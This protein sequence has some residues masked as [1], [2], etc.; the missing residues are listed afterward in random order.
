MSVKT[1]KQKITFFSLLMLIS[2]QVFANRMLTFE[3]PV[4]VKDSDSV[5]KSIKIE[6]D[7]Q[8]RII[9]LKNLNTYEYSVKYGEISQIIVHK[10]NDTQNEYYDLNK[11][12]LN[13]SDNEI[14]F[15][16]KNANINYIE[17]WKFSKGLLTCTEQTTNLIEHYYLYKKIEDG[18]IAN[19][20]EFMQTETRNNKQ[21]NFYE[22]SIEDYNF[23]LELINQIKSKNQ[24]INILNSKVFLELEFEY[25][26]P[27][28]LIDLDKLFVTVESYNATSELKEKNAS[29]VAENLRKKEGLPWA[30]ANGYGIGEKINILLPTSYFNLYF[31]N[32]FQ[33]DSRKD[34]YKANSRV[35]KIRI[36][37]C[38]I[39]VSKEFIIKDVPEAQ[40]INLEDLCL[41]INVFTNL[42]ITILEIYPGEKYKDLCI[43]A[44]IPVY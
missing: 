8:G 26:I 12:N 44:I 19:Y 18:F 25:F 24:E 3:I 5:Y 36:R 42:E 13:V 39:D 35:K 9:Y 16:K 4:P 1:K 40:Y 23:P 17:E 20:I 38:E 32:G 10:T 7:E 14:E 37:N 11:T 31:Y 30:S 15:T 28:L 2:F 21:L 41:D 27:I 29:Y 34:L 6:L 43:Q 22:E 33:S